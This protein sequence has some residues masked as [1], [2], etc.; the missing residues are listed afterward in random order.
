MKTIFKYELD[1]AA[2][3]EVTL[4][5]DATIM[6]V[7]FQGETLCL[8]ALVDPDSEP[9]KRIFKIYGTGWTVD[10]PGVLTHVATVQ[11]RGYVWHLFE[12]I[13]SGESDD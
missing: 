11:K 5:S 10:C 9:K 12:R 2:A 6:D 4:P 1:I 8:W 3:Q 13:E 7:Q